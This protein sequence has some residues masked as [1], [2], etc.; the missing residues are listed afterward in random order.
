VA[1]RHSGPYP[2]KLEH[3]EIPPCLE[4]SLPVLGALVFETPPI[5][6][7]GEKNARGFSEKFIFQRDDEFLPTW[8]RV[9]GQN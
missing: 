6:A 8:A 7:E 5:L 3:F 1:A 2:S 9:Y 4:A